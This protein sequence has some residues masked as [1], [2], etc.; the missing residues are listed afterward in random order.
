MQSVILA[1]T[2]HL[3]TVSHVQ[4]LDLTASSALTPFL[5]Q[6]VLS[7]S[8]GQNVA[9]VLLATQNLFAIHAL[10]DTTLHHLSA[11]PALVSVSNVI[12]VLNHR[13]AVLVQQVILEIHAM[14]A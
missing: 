13:S 4:Q 14:L 1:T 9:H 6:S 3:L 5:V 8:Q 2:L 7:D 10:M 12:C 11:S